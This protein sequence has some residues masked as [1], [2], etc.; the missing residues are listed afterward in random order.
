MNQQ[1][2]PLKIKIDPTSYA[3]GQK[4]P[5]IKGVR[6]YTGMGLKEA[7]EISE[8]QVPSVILNR[9]SMRD[10]ALEIEG[11]K[12]IKQSGA[13]IISGGIQ[14]IIDHLENAIR[15]ALDEGYYDMAADIL[16]ILKQ[17]K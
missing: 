17:T 15:I 3:D 14:P 4:I 7:K 13:T 16:N 12:Q 6:G 11:I 9:R 8:K 2:I 10:P 5:F 1:G